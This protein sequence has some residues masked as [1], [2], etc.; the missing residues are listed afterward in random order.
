MGCFMRHNAYRDGKVHVQSEEC[1]TGVFR[2]GNL[3]HLQPGR[4]RGDGAFCS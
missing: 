2:K 1:S 3:M 4:L